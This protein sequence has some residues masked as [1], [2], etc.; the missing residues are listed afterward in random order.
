VGVVDREGSLAT[1]DD[2]ADIAEAVDPER[3][4]PVASSELEPA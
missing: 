3:S 1:K 2:E 4:Q